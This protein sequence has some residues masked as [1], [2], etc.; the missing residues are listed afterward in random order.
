[1][2]IMLALKVTPGQPVLRGHDHFWQVIREIGANGAAWSVPEVAGRCNGP[3]L[4]TTNE[5]VRNFVGRLVRGGYAEVAGREPPPRGRVLYRLTRRPRET[6]SLKRDGSPALDRSGQR[7]MWNA[8]R[9]LKQFTAPHLAVVAS[10]DECRV[11]PSTA[12]TYVLRLA[13]AG[14]LTVREPGRSGKPAVWRLRA[15]YDTGPLPPV[16]LRS[17]MVWDQNRSAIVGKVVAEEDRP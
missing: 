17:K 15:S 7:Q 11:P 12:L 1:M 9:R 10:T 13:A 16:V 4:R 8:I 3:T 5:E 2:G 14:Y 6:P